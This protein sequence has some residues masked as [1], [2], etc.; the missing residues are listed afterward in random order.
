MEAL[1]VG[2]A[3]RMHPFWAQIQGK[4]ERSVQL[5]PLMRFDAQDL[6]VLKN[7]I[8]G[9]DIRL[10]ALRA[11]SL[12]VGLVALLLDAVDALLHTDRLLFQFWKRERIRAVLDWFHNRLAVVTVKAYPGL[13]SQQLRKLKFLY[14][15]LVAT[16]VFY[17]FHFKLEIIN[18]LAE[19]FKRVRLFVRFLVNLIDQIS[20][21]WLQLFRLQGSLW[22]VSQHVPV[23]SRQGRFLLHKGEVRIQHAREQGLQSRI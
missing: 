15:R 8:F 4:A 5:A 1:F 18:E 9:P 16:G 14:L 6:W 3:I 20:D 23:E 19:G 22:G 7:L 12:G 17:C 13:K 10:L 2:I 11:N 21:R